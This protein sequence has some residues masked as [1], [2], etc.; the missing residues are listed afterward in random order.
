MQALG[1]PSDDPIYRKTTSGQQRGIR[2][3]EKTEPTR[4]EGSIVTW[5]DGGVSEAA[6]TLEKPMNSACPADV[7]QREETYKNSTTEFD[8]SRS[9]TYGK[10][11]RFFQIKQKKWYWQVSRIPE[12][13]FCEGNTVYFLPR[14]GWDGYKYLYLEQRDLENFKKIWAGEISF[15]KAVYESIGSRS[16]G[17]L[18][19]SRDSEILNLRLVD[20]K[21]GQILTVWA[22]PKKND[23]RIKAA[24]TKGRID[25]EN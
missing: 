22:T 12:S 6:G 1:L 24:R 9:L 13:T 8:P 21:S 20:R 23:G 11:S 14:D 4:Y 15:S 25:N 16:F 18:S 17:L 2:E 3:Y 19:V 10:K 7:G 5:E